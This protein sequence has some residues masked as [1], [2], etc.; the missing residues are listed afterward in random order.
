MLRAKV[1]V[2]CDWCSGSGCDW[3]LQQHNTHDSLPVNLEIPSK[4]YQPI[5]MSLF[6]VHLPVTVRM[7]RGNIMLSVVHDLMCVLPPAE[8]GQ[9]VRSEEVCLGSRVTAVRAAGQHTWHTS[10]TLGQCSLLFG[11]CIILL[12]Q[13]IL[14]II[15]QCVLLLKQCIFL[16]GHC[17]L[18][19]GQCTLPFRQ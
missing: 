14:F 2:R 10:L 17:I 15:G 16:F 8:C 19:L 18:T 11:Q 13:C 5:V 4:G 12:R 6:H 9:R 7:L 1:S 3:L